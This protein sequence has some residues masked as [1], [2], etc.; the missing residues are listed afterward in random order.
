[1][2]HLTDQSKVPLGEPA[3]VPVPV[4]EGNDQIHGRDPA[5]G[6]GLT[7]S[8]GVRDHPNAAVVI[9][10]LRSVGGPDRESIGGLTRVAPV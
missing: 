6:L 1:M 10:D 4:Q 9:G 5:E 7:G 8:V 2:V 3:A